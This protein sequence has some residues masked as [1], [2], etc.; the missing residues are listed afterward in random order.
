ME[1]S[2]MTPHSDYDIDIFIDKLCEMNSKFEILGTI[3]NES[4]RLGKGVG[5]FKVVN[6]LL[7]ITSKLPFNVVKLSNSIYEKLF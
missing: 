3:R 2:K 7:L 5:K 6:L 4:D 1:S